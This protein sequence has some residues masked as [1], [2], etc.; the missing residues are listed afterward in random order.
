MYWFV[1][2]DVIANYSLELRIVREYSFDECLDLDIGSRTNF[3]LNYSGQMEVS[4]RRE[5]LDFLHSN[6]RI[7]V[8]GSSVFH[9]E[10]ALAL[11]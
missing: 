6:R 11:A 1:E 10:K 7:F 5:L 8:D 9:S 3:L 4:R 2:Q